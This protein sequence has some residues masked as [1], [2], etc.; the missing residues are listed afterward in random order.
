MRCGQSSPWL[1]HHSTA[2][3][4]T[5]LCTLQANPYFAAGRVTVPALLDT[6]A[7]Q[8]FFN[9][10]PARPPPPLLAACLPCLSC[11]VAP[12]KGATPGLPC[13]TCLQHVAAPTHRFALL[14][15]LCAVLPPPACR[16][17]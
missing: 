8:S 5:R 17:C 15:E 12:P 16:V 7:C 14:C 1:T 13:T 3:E 6:F 2:F 10:V 9:E 4:L 11:C